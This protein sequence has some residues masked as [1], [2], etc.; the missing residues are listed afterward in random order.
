MGYFTVISKRSANDRYQLVPR[1]HADYLSK[2]EPDGHRDAL[3]GDLVVTLEDEGDTVRITGSPA[4]IPKV[5]DWLFSREITE[6][7]SE[8]VLVIY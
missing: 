7:E 2:E 8:S 3:Q 5:N 6:S 1:R 4:V